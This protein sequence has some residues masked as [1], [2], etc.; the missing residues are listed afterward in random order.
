M[1]VLAIG[2]GFATLMFGLFLVAVLFGLPIFERLTT[3]AIQILARRLQ[4]ASEEAKEEF[5]ALKTKD[6][7]PLKPQFKKNISAIKNKKTVL[8]E[9]DSVASGGA[10]VA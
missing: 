5:R 6:I 10:R 9:P 3:K 7:P 1:S 4:I 2:F 8:K